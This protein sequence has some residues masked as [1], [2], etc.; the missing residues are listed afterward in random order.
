MK[1]RSLLI[2]QIWR[3][4]PM[5]KLLQLS[6][7]T[8]KILVIVSSVPE[9]QN[10]MQQLLVATTVHTKSSK[11]VTFWV[12]GLKKSS[13]KDG[14]TSDQSQLK[15][16]ILTS[17]SLSGIQSH[18]NQFWL[19]WDKLFTSSLMTTSNLLLLFCH[20]CQHSQNFTMVTR[21]QLEM[22]NNSKQWPSILGRG[23]WLDSSQPKATNRSTSEHHL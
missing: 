18:Q 19:K 8:K 3:E 16:E 10:K 12:L 20:I 9:T 21:H 11:D 22:L 15:N 6:R 4:L 13:W 14:F 23:N 7:K 1:N 5:K 2:N 17:H